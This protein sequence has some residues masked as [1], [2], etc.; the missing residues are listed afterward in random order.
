MTGVLGLYES[1]R[2]RWDLFRIQSR[3]GDWGRGK[4]LCIGEVCGISA[5]LALGGGKLNEGKREDHI[6]AAKAL[7][8]ER[9]DERAIGV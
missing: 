2:G 1:Q 8:P 5:H 3:M 7:Q 4:G 9:R 6:I